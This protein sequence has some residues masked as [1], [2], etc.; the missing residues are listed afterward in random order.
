MPY[1]P[2]PSGASKTWTSPLAGSS[3]PIVPVPWPVNQRMPSLSNVGVCGPT[4]RLFGIGNVVTSWLTGSTRSIV[5][6]PDR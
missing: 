3:R 5:L 4:G 6:L 2:G 1:G